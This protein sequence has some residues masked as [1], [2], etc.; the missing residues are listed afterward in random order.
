M[1]LSEVGEFGFISRIREKSPG[2]QSVL[3][4]IGDDAAATIM[5]PGMVLLSTADMLAEGIHFDLAWSDPACLGRKSLAVNLSDIAAMGGIPR[6]ALLSVAIPPQLS[7]EFMESF[8]NGF[9][10][11]AG[12]FGVSLIGGDTSSS[13]DGLVISV[14]LLGEQYPEK[15]ARRSGAAVGDIICVSG[16]LGDSALG[17]KLLKTGCLSGEALRRHLDPV[18]RVELGRALAERG[19]ATAMIDVSD[20]L[21]ADLGHILESS[22][23][24]ARVRSDAIPLSASFTSS[25]QKS[26][27]DYYRLPLSGGEDYELLFTLHPSKLKDAEDAAATAGTPIAV[28]GEINGD[29]GLFI[30]KSDGS[31]YDMK[32]SGYDHFSPNAKESF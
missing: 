24:G 32:S 28:I 26:S 18:P 19:I 6:Y 5:T 27:Q 3:L 20:G 29:S 7:L 22:A 14:T 21:S 30:A 12:N 16:T 25:V 17:L 9:L 2:S 8:I 1:K 11:Q 15:I 13:K 10:E 23:K 4:G 31:S